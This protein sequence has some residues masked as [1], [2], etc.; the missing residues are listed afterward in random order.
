MKL[1]LYFGVVFLFFPLLTALVPRSQCYAAV[2]LY[3][4]CDIACQIVFP[5]QFSKFTFSLLAS[6][7]LKLSFLQ[8]F[9]VVHW[10]YYFFSMP[11]SLQKNFFFPLYY[12]SEHGSKLHTDFKVD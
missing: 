2:V 8:R 10:G 4:T 9:S 12:L 3:Y 5:V 7:Q 1:D 6:L 11:G